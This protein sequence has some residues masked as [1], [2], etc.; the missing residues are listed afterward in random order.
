MPE[1]QNYTHIGQ[2]IRALRLERGWPQAEVAAKVGI[3]QE[4]VS[5]VENGA[6]GFINMKLDTISRFAAAF[7][8]H[9]ADLILMISRQEV[10]A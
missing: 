6:E 2:A 10:Q 4:Y 7:D 3:T 9:A 1:P 5:R 8:L